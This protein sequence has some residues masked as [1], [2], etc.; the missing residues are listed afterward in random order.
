MG[1]EKQPLHGSPGMYSVGIE[2]TVNL[3]NYENRRVGLVMSFASE[4]TKPED[5]YAQVRAIVDGW[6]ADIRFQKGNVQSMVNEALP[7]PTGKTAIVMDAL[8]PYMDRILITDAPSVILIKTRGRMERE[9][10]GELDVIIR[11]QGGSWKGT[12]DGLAG[13]DVH[14]EIPK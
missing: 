14:W 13:K 4:Q 9:K 12:R 7:P 8:K 6:A 5:A 10:W 2:A 1:M 3:G 11:A